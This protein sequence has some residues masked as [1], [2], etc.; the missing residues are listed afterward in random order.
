MAGILAESGIESA[1]ADANELI[2]AALGISRAEVGNV[3]V[4]EAEAV[5]VLT[6]AVERARGAPLQYVTG[7]AAF[8]HIELRVGPGVLVPRPETE[9]V[10]E[11]ALAR[12]PT[13]GLCVDVGTGSGAIALSIA[14]ERPDATV[15]ATDSAPDAVRWARLNSGKLGLQVEVVECDLLEG[16]TDELAGKID[17]IVSNPPYIGTEERGLLPRDVV[18]YEPPEALFAGERGMDVIERLADAARGWLAPGGWLVLEVAP[19]QADRVRELLE[20]LDYSFVSIAR[21]LAGRNRVAEGRR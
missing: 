21:D 7:V 19:H 8:R 12:L 3:D 18:E 14:H 2:R 15:V 10:T 20:G 5:R 11:H 17:V 6:L 1:E 16:L 9:I 13:G 4:Q